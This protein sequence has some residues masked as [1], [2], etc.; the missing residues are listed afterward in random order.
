MRRA[1]AS[2]FVLSSI[3]F[4]FSALPSCSS[5]E[6][7]SGGT[8]GKAGDSGVGGS[9]GSGTGGVSSSCTDNSECDDGKACNGVETCASGKCAAGTNAECT[10]PDAE[11][12]VA[13]CEDGTG[14]DGCTIVAKD[15]DGDGHGDGQ[16]AA[17]TD[18]DDCDDTNPNVSPEATEACNGI[19]DDCDGKDDLSDGFQTYGAEFEL[20]VPPVGASAYQPA[21]VWGSDSYAMTWVDTR[22]ANKARIYFVLVNPDGSLKTTPIALSDPAFPAASVRPDIAWN[23]TE[24]AVTWNGSKYIRVGT[25]GVPKTPVIQ[26]PKSGNFTRIVWTGASWQ[27]GYSHSAVYGLSVSATDQPGEETLIGGAANPNPSTVGSAFVGDTVGYVWENIPGLAQP[28][29]VYFARTDASLTVLGQGAITPDPPPVGESN[30]GPRIGVVADRFGIA[31]R[32]TLNGTDTAEYFERKL[33]GSPAC[34]PLVLESSNAGVSSPWPQYVGKIGNRTSILLMDGTG[35]TAD[36]KLAR[37]DDGCGLVDVVSL[38]TSYLVF[39]ERNSMW[40][41]GDKGHILIWVEGDVTGSRAIHA[42]VFGPNLC[43]GPT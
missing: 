24:F 8:G 13:E 6:F 3:P 23:G 9:A 31:Y 1:L 32:R 16:C 41:K 17:A 33:D 37:L 14:S 27:V 38:A 40:A 5:D 7:E 35:Q 12:C 21:I 36:L 2:L 39:P 26:L 43:D 34:G 19:D 25:D 42:R 11:H 28:G 22:D 30:L 20:L 15:G 29:A 18:A 10:N 4:L